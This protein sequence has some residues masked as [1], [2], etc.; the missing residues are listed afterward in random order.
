MAATLPPSLRGLNPWLGRAV[1]GGFSGVTGLLVSGHKGGESG[2][3]DLK[4]LTLLSVMQL[5]CRPRAYLIGREN[6]TS[7][8]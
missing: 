4:T 1:A 2:H 5:L 8:A 6:T 3:L 7:V